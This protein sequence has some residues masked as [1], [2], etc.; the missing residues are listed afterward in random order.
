MH[1]TYLLTADI[2]TSFQLNG[3]LANLS[4]MTA[5][6][7]MYIHDIQDHLVKRKKYIYMYLL[8]IIFFRD[9]QFTF[10]S[11]QITHM[12]NIDLK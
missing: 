3:K 11:Y 4:G 12:I 10:N 8:K 9:I 6:N 1:V 2:V 7:C 5:L